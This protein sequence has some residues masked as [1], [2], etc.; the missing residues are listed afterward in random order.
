MLATS[1]CAVMVG[2]Q[3]RPSKFK[4]ISPLEYTW[5]CFG[6]GFKKYTL[7]AESQP[8]NEKNEIR[9]DVLKVL[10]LH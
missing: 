4:H 9:I 2:R 6:V 8:A 10:T 3:S 1:N 5:T 7:G